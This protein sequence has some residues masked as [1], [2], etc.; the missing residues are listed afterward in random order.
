MKISVLFLASVKG[1][2]AVS[3]LRIETSKQGEKQ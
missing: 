3:F 2:T 1:E